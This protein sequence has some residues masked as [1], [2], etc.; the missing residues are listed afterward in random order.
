MKKSILI[1]GGSGNL[2]RA[3]IEKFLADGHRVIASVSAGKSLGFETSGDLDTFTA[4]LTNEQNTTQ[5]IE[6]VLKKNKTIDAALL[7]VGGFAMGNIAQAD[8]EALKKMFSVNFETAYYTARPVFQHMLT[9]PTGGKIIFVGSRPP[10]QAETGKNMVAYAL[11]KSLIFKLA[12]LL[13]AEGASKNVKTS[14]IVPS[15]IDTPQNRRDMPNADFSRWVKP[16]EIADAID[17]I[18]SEKG[19]TFQDVVLKMGS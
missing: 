6:Q 10:L 2:G 12:E 7:L 5:A 4:D 15:T 1:T 9:Q 18:I 16:E 11:S 14:V 19:K 8:G 13:N 17:I 3:C